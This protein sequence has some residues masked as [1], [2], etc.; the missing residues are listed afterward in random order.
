MLLSPADGGQ[1]VGPADV[2]SVVCL[3]LSGHLK[4][5]ELQKEARQTIYSVLKGRG[6]EIG[7]IAPATMQVSALKQDGGS[8]TTMIHL[9]SG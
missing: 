5:E 1:S 3:L 2:I 7:I 4:E 9:R 6:G 8:S